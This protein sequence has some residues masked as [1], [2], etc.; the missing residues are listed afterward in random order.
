MTSMMLLAR[1]KK[2]AR[3]KAETNMVMKPYW[4]TISRYS[5]NRESWVQAWRL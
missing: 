3:G 5:S 2:G 4:M 1:A